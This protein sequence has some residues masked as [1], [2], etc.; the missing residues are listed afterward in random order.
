MNDL[1]END[2]SKNTIV[3]LSKEIREP[4][5][6]AEIRGKAFDAFQTSPWPAPDEEEWRRTNLAEFGFGDGDIIGDLL[7]SHSGGNGSGAVDPAL[8]E[9]AKPW[10]ERTA[11]LMDNRFAAL[12]MALWTDSRIVYVPDGVVIDEPLV[13]EYGSVAGKVNNIHTVVVLGRESKATVVQRFTGG[14]YETIWNTGLTA[15]LGEGAKL[16]FANIQNIE[17]TGF[18]FG[19]YRYFLDDYSL[20]RSF[21]SYTGG[22]LTKTRNE[23]FIDGSAAEAL[24]D[25]VYF[26]TDNQHMDMRTVQYHSRRASQSRAF[27][28]G[29]VSGNGR[30]VYQ[31]LI[32][33]DEKA[34]G[35][36]A[37]LTNK[38][39]ILNDG[40]RADSI[41]CLEIRTDDVKC[42]H[43]STSGRLDE[44]AL[45]YLMSRGL[46]R[47]QAREELIAGFFEDVIEKAPEAAGDFVRTEILKLIS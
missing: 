10:L 4:K 14:G 30:S 9:T 8:V 32:D 25:G 42:S 45:F 37:Y 33:V 27:F 22:R 6:L 36:D 3:E 24:L 17:E 19:Q 26:A 28:K 44:E 39:L 20:L 15:G 34:P 5:W 16:S 40:A 31:G 7:V 35:T 43:G 29:A 1:V 13:V 23:V 21:E 41:P 47:G 18:F 46:T 38:N 2:V 12:N 11:S